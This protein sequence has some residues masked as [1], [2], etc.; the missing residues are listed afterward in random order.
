M[1]KKYSQGRQ[2]E[3]FDN[4][5]H[6]RWCALWESSKAQPTSMGLIVIAFLYHEREVLL[7]PCSFAIHRPCTPPSPC[8]RPHCSLS[9]VPGVTACHV[10]QPTIH[11]PLYPLRTIALHTPHYPHIALHSALSTLPCPTVP[12]RTITPNPHH[13]HLRIHTQHDCPPLLTWLSIS[14]QVRKKNLRDCFRET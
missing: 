13:P 14:L 4:R 1:G 8:L 5:F 12:L 9:S 7:L 2:A 11:T 6:R 3:E 10:Q